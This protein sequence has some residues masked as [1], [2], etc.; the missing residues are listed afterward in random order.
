M[1]WRE[2]YQSKLI[3]MS[4]AVGMV[5]SGMTLSIGIAASEPVGILEELA[6]QA[7]RLENVTTW[8]CLPMRAYDIFMK[9]EMEG[10][11]FNENW[12]YGAP[13]R[14]VHHEG[15]V[16]YTPNNLHKAGTDKLIGHNGKL[17]MMLGVCTPPNADGMVSLSMGA[18]V[19]RE[20]IDAADMVVLE[21]N[22]NLPW[23]D[24]DV[25][26]PLSMVDHF[27]EFDSPL[28]QVPTSTPNDIDELIGHNVAE[29]IEDGCTV[30]LGIGG[31]PTAVADFISDRKN[32]GIH[33]ELLVDG[34]YKLC[35]SGAVNGSRKTLLPGKIVA[36]FA[37]GTQPLYDF[38]NESDDV[39]LMR[40]SYVNNPYVIAKNY[41][42]ISI[43][44]AIQVDV[45]GQV[46]SQSIGTRHFSGTGGQLDTH[47]G[48][49]MSEGGKGIIALRSTA[50]NGTIS[51]I[52][53]TLAPGAGVTVPSQDVDTIV[54]EYGSAQL[55][56][57]S[58]KKRMEALIKIAH[59]DFRESIREESHRLG[60]VPDRQFF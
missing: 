28:V 24:G 36:T 34:V 4:E 55:R 35:A 17:D 3:R 49:Q 47:R 10:R 26:I 30:Q 38:M 53:P 20:M 57:L 45:M 50:K 39:L 1:N 37:I 56:G 22:R 6:R 41:R 52:V 11:F 9:P 58:V 13:D 42:M 18:V 7:D 21:V 33:S 44:T 54:T 12:F 2:E 23:V 31:M 14:A 43:N 32:L 19:E 25:V 51:T 15:R 5:Q 46:C 40:G 59:P 27:V 60:I 48:A 29:F 8:T 16:S